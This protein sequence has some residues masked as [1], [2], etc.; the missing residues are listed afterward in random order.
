[1]TPYRFASAD[2]LLAQLEG[3]RVEW[4]PAS[5]RAD[6][7]LDRPPLN[8]VAMAER[9]Q[10]AAVFGA[11]DRDPAVRVVV[12]RSAG[13]NFSSGGDIAGFLAASP[14][15]VSHLADNVAAP[16]RCSKPVIAAVR[17]YCFGVGFEL[18]LACDFRLASETAEFALPEMRIGMIPGSGGSARLLQMIGIARTKDMAMRAR[19][20]PAAAAKEWGF[21]TDA[22]PDGE[23]DAAVG[24][25]VDELRQFSPLA[26]RA[27]KHVLNQGQHLPLRGAIEL[28]GQAYGRLR[29]SA[30][31]QEGV[32]S[33]VE[34][35]KPKFR[36]E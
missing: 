28:E 5:E 29:G 10:L 9:D 14:E 24:R 6:I 2:A 23:L 4:E 3:F 30:D 34:K 12:L 36:G 15:H 26:Q 16:E 1:M 11:L 21:V 33:F 8:V 25:L 19:R 31:F 27:I 32:A 17:G 18:S 13:K 7:V 22:V 35:R 20:V